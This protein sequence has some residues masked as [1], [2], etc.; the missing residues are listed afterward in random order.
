MLTCTYDFI[1]H[2]LVLDTI[3]LQY[4]MHAYIVVRVNMRS[5]RYYSKGIRVPRNRL[6]SHS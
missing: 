1:M 6:W 5:S 2:L 3:C 4:I